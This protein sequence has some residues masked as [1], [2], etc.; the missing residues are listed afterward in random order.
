MS[1]FSTPILLY[2]LGAIVYGCDAAPPS[3]QPLEASP[4]LPEIASAFVHTDAP[5]NLSL[6]DP[7]G[8]LVATGVVDLDGIPNPDLILQGTYHLDDA[9]VGYSTAGDLH[10][11]Y[12]VAA[13]ECADHLSIRFDP[14]VSDGG[15]ELVT[16]CE[17]PALSGTWYQNT[18]AGRQA[19]G[20]FVLE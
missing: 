20:T 13:G 16:E 7:S 15:L 3:S 1:R 5:M 9:G 19:Q 8:A 11:A 12:Y 14:R 10:A 4:Q 18:I 6:Y 2:C 17:A